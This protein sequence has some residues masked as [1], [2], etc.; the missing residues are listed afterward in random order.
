MSPVDFMGD[1]PV[2]SIFLSQVTHAEI[3]TILNT[4]KNGAPGYDEINACLPKQISHCIVDPLTH[5]CN[6]SFSEGIFPD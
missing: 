4:L 1:P 2:N 3:S 6:L 5:V